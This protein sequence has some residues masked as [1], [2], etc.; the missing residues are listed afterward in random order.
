MDEDKDANEQSQSKQQKKNKQTNSMENLQ[1]GQI[2][3]RNNT[4]VP[5]FESEDEDGFP[6]SKA[7]L[8]KKCE[9]TAPEQADDETTDKVQKK[10]KRGVKTT[11]QEEQPDR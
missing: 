10:N 1:E 5:V 11:E 4:S 7:A 8:N 3:P 9:T 2:V 6:I